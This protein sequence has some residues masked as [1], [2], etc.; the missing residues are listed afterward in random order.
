M[1]LISCFL[2]DIIFASNNSKEIVAN[3]QIV[4]YE[5]KIEVC[6]KLMS[7]TVCASPKVVQSYDL[8]SSLARRLDLLR[9][10]LVSYQETLAS[11]ARGSAVAITIN[12]TVVNSIKT[13]SRGFEPAIEKPQIFY[14]VEP[15]RFWST[16]H[17]P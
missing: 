2:T 9:E 14:L 10:L 6:S 3:L 13:A 11:I 12:R 7:V 8:K 15:G 17:F 1:R 4:A 5:R 16:P